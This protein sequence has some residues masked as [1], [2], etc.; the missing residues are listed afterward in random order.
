MFDLNDSDKPI[1]V[2]IIDSTRGTAVT[3]T[4]LLRQPSEAEVLEYSRRSTRLR[5]SQDSAR[6]GAEKSV[7]FEDASAPARLW[8]WEKLILSV[9]GYS[10]GGKKIEGELTAEARAKIPPRHKLAAAGHFDSVISLVE[11]AAKNSSPPSG[12]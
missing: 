2:K 10:L 9:G 8:L 6:S 5:L 3:V 11:E 12:S 4:H 7:E 1:E